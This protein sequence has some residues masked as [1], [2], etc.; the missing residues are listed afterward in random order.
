MALGHGAARRS[1]HRVTP[2]LGVASLAFGVWYPPGAL[3]LVPYM[4]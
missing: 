1:L 3:T 4:L 2:A